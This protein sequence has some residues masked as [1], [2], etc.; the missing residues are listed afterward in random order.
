MIFDVVVSLFVVCVFFMF[1]VICL[2]SVFMCA[3]YV[4]VVSLRVCFL[5]YLF[6]V[7]LFAA[8]IGLWA[9]FVVVTGCH[10]LRAFFAYNV[11]CRC[12][13]C[14]FFACLRLFVQ[15]FK[16]YVPRLQVAL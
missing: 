13:L 2:F 8:N 4:I 15:F 14:C 9:L 10:V 1:I 6:M 12:D 11:S 7:L 3:F 5:C 16:V